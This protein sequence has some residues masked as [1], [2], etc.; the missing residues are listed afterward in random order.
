MKRSRTNDYHTP[1][2]AAIHE[3]ATDLAPSGVVKKRTLRELD[4]LC[5]TRVPPLAPEQIKEL[6]GRE[7]VSQAVLASYVNVTPNAVSQ[8]ERGEKRPAGA[9]LKMLWL[10]INGGLDAIR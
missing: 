10:A 9:A 7:G 4:A 5:L 1:L 6:R 8:W 3:A 2:L